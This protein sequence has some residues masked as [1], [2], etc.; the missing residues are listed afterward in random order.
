MN[1]VCVGGGPAGLFFAVCARRRDPRLSVR[2]VERYVPSATSGWGVT[3][4][5]RLMNLVHENDPETGRQLRARSVT[6]RE[7]E[8]QLRG[9]SAYVPQFRSGLERATMLDVLTRRAVELG[10]E[11]E[12]GTAVNDV[13]AIR[14]ADLVIA[15]DGVGSQVRRQFAEHFGTT[16]T[17]GRNRYIWLGTDRVLPRMTFPFVRTDAGWIWMH[18]YPSSRSFSTCVVECP[19]ETWT[20][21]G[22]DTMPTDQ[23]LK[24]LAELFAE[25]LRGRPLTGRSAEDPGSWRRFQHL[26][27]E[28]WWHENVVLMGDAAHASHFSW[29]SGTRLA[30]T[31]ASVLAETLARHRD[32]P[33]ALAEYEERRR[34][35]AN[36]T[37][38]SAQRRSVRWER[39]D[40]LLEQDVLTFMHAKSGRYDEAALRRLRP[41]HRA[42]Q[43]GVVRTAGM[44]A[45]V[46]QRWYV[47]R[48]RWPSGDGPPAVPARA[49][50]RSGA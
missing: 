8:W 34:P 18:A 16:T 45:R 32:L 12:V 49:R 41:L 2:V 5:D 31:D 1:V 23:G 10:A 37:V 15:A 43:L 13:A 7:Q 11:V 33:A 22:L 50:V 40:G 17:T 44:Q 30:V 27:N 19:P 25:P 29:A 35:K 24:L 39:L 26:T 47:N 46:A 36:R 28:S 3:Y 48:R 42:G 21:L 6:W 9:R 14:D 20:G 4:S 38:A